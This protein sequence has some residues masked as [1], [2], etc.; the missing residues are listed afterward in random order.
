MV[1][2]LVLILVF[3]CFPNQ[4]AIFN[5]KTMEANKITRIIDAKYKT[6]FYNSLYAGRSSQQSQPGPVVPTEQHIA[7]KH[8]VDRHYYGTT[9]QKSYGQE[10]YHQI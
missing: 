8:E 5:N 1:Y 2:S 9:Y 3:C 10:T 4:S 7:N 6:K